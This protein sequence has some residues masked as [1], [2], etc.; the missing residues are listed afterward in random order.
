[1]KYEKVAVCF[2]GLV[3]V[4]ILNVS[5]YA[6]PQWNV[7]F[8]S[9]TAG[10]QPQI[11]PAVAGVVN[12]KPTAIN[13]GGNNSILVQSN[14]NAGSGSLNNQ[15]VV[16]S[17]L[18]TSVSPSP[19]L[20]FRSPV[21]DYE[22]GRVFLLDFDLL[23]SST[24]LKPNAPVFD[25]IMRRNG[26]GTTIANFTLF[27]T[28][29]KAMMTSS[30]NVNPQ[31]IGYFTNVWSPDKVMH[32]TLAYDPEDNEFKS[33]I[34]GNDV[35]S[36]PL[37]QD[38]ENQ[39]V[40]EFYISCSANSS[41]SVLAVDNIVS[42]TEEPDYSNEP[43][44][45]PGG[46][47]FGDDTLEMCFQPASGCFD[48]FSIKTKA[49]DVIYGGWRGNSDAVM[50]RLF[51]RDS[52]LNQQQIN[53][54]SPCQNRTYNITQQG[55]KDILTFQWTGITLNGQP[56]LVDV[57]VEL[58]AEPNK[59]GIEWDIDIENRS[60]S[61]GVW[62]TYFPYIRCI[63][64]GNT[65]LNDYLAYPSGAGRLIPNPFGDIA[66]RSNYEAP[67]S[68]MG[69]PSSHNMQWAA[70][71]D[72]NMGGLYF[73]THDP[74][75]YRKDFYYLP[76][77]GQYILC[78]VQ[79]PENKGQ[80]GLDYSSP[81]SVLTRYTPGHWYDASQIYREWALQQKWAC[82]GNLADRDDIPE[83][84]KDTPLYFV[85]Y[86]SAGD[87][88]TLKTHA[89]A[90]KNYFGYD[91]PVP[92]NWYNW[93]VRFP[94]QT[95][96]ADDDGTC[97][98]GQNM[99][100]KDGYAAALS[101]LE[102]E[103]VYVQPYI[104]SRIYDV[105]DLDDPCLPTG[106]QDIAVKD[107]LGN[108]VIWNASYPGLLD[109]CRTQQA[110]QDWMTDTATSLAENC[111]AKGAYMDQFGK[112]HN[113]CFDPSHGHPLGGGDWQTDAMRQFAQ[114]VRSSCKAVDE[115][116]VF[117]GEDAAEICIDVL[118]GDLFHSDLTPAY[119]P[120][121]HAVYHDYWVFY[122]RALHSTFSDIT[123]FR[124]TTGN[125]FTY[126]TKL[127]RFD[128]TFDT[129]MTQPQYVAFMSRLRKLAR[130][131]Y[132]ARKHLEYGRMLRPIKFDNNVPDVNYT[133]SGKA[134]SSPAIMSSIWEA[135]DKSVGLVLY[136]ISGTTQQY[137]ITLTSDVYPILA[138]PLKR[139]EY[140]S[141]GSRIYIDTW[142]SPSMTLS[143][144]MLSDNVLIYEFEHIPQN[145]VEV[146]QQGFGMATDVN[147]DC[148][149]NLSDFS[150]IAQ[151]WLT[152]DEEGLESDFDQDNCINFGDLKLFV[153]DWLICNDPEGGELCGANW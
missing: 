140:A 4:L 147:H 92:L 47:T 57:T 86:G 69:Y 52:S 51:M 97:H 70:I 74:N 129:F 67:I 20:T 56:G 137:Q 9:M 84:Y 54:H 65:P 38:F 29:W 125:L 23:I 96:R 42:S 22:I 31:Q 34:D 99:V 75:A 112:I 39:G 136:N 145:C 18:D 114:G 139:Y 15:P 2:Y 7:D 88:G 59:Q 61:Y 62:E 117:S 17:H 132:G 64:A 143:G 108:Y 106:W 8:N 93:Q 150:A 12:T 100:A 119:C 53:N 142:D 83:W 87:I 63:P 43:N 78:T 44:D 3:I 73:A 135:P 141:D 152:C 28:D 126:G 46:I 128:V 76:M 151:G 19:T 94:D 58:T 124:F 6:I 21:E 71:Y 105:P 110:Y 134:Y 40:I 77:T 60:T 48:L 98:T 121:V 91:G 138:Q 79:H 55:N 1:M 41:Y 95:S 35:G 5:V 49:D 148:N 80:A 89:I 123:K 68:A 146:W 81:Y 115:D 102:I 16:F 30:D 36:I 24:N 104:N 120:L 107:I 37:A 127:G 133:E 101:E 113:D 103:G 109:M 131:K 13:V 149:I 85:C 26:T 116:S 122:G 45:L 144:E 50:F 14:F 10:Q 118:D 33:I 72:A 111:N 82:K 11:E 27:T 25:V 90:Y 66:H 32:V 153:D 130:Y